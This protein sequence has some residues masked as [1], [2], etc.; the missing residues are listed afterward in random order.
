MTLKVAI[1]ADDLT[2]AL[3]TGTPFVDAGLSVAVA[4]DVGAIPETLATDCEVAVVN[5]ASRALPEEEA[6]RKV[7]AAAKALLAA[8]PQIVLK[9]IDSRL[10]GNVAAE[11]AAL[12]A[13][14]GHEAIVVSPAI[15]DQERLTRSGHVVGRGVG[16]A[17]PISVLF[18]TSD[19][20]VTVRDAETDSD[21]DRVVDAYDW[22]RTL[23]VGARG[24]GS[25]LARKIGQPNS[26]NNPFATSSRTVFAFGSRDPITAAQM[27]KLES[28]GGLVSTIDAPMG[29]LPPEARFGLPILLRCTGEITSEAAAVADRFAKG[30]KSVIDATSPEMLMVGGGDTALAVF[31]EL[32]IRTL[33]PKGEIEA[34]IPWFDVNTSDGLHLHCAVKSGGF[35]NSDSLLRLIAQNQAA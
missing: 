5:T 15:P 31:R 12:A 17:L 32:G 27:A 10:K 23:A 24:I 9:K 4:I 34:G 19:H 16:E 25:A 13:V 3:D 21:L 14:F 35:G 30:V 8:S 22:R 1:I 2:G 29:A 33:R 11:S 26:A 6:A 28:S 7:S 20:Q 18:E